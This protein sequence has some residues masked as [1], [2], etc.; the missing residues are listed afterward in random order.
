MKKL[1]SLF[2][3]VLLSAVFV[4]AEEGAAENS[5]KYRFGIG[6][7]VPCGG[8]GLG[9]EAYP[10]DKVSIALG[11]GATPGGLGWAAGARFY[12]SVLESGA[13]RGGS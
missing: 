6:A 7:G 12:V 4:Y 5:G 2:T 10:M 8:F 3:I 13:G 11:L 9:L 1:V